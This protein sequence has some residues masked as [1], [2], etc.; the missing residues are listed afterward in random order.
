MQEF[1]TPNIALQKLRTQ[2]IV[3]SGKTIHLGGLI[4]SKVANAAKGLPGTLIL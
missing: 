3:E 2:V 1:K 4:A